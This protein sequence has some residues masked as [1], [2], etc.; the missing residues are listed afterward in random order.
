MT[1]RLAS[2]HVRVQA[3][4]V[5]VTV[6]TAAMCARDAVAQCQYDVSV[7]HG[8]WCGDIFQ[9][10]P[11]YVRGM[12]EAGDVVGYYKSCDLGPERA[13]V[14]TADAGL[15]T[16]N[17]PGASLSWAEDIAEQFIVGRFLD[18]N[19]EF[20]NMAFVSDGA[21]VTLIPPPP[22]NFLSA[23]FAVNESGQVVGTFASGV[24]FL[25]QD[26]AMTLFGPFP[27]GW[28]EARDVNNLGQVVGH[29]GDPSHLKA[30]A[31]A[32]IWENGDVTTLN[33]I[34]GGLTSVG[35][36][37]ND[38]G[39]VVGHGLIDAEELVTHP[40]I[41]SDGTMTDIGTL[42]GSSACFALD[43]NDRGTVVGYCAEFEGQF[44]VQ[45]AFIW[46]N[47]QM[48][49]LNDVISWEFGMAKAWA[50][51]NNG[52][53]TGDAV[54]GGGALLLTPVESPVGDINGDCQ[55]GIVDFLLLL[56]NWG[57]CPTQGA[58]VADVDGDGVVGITDF[59]LLLTNWG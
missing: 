1:V 19:T 11:T 44:N 51:N 35:L 30:T 34:P 8:P 21:S 49:D 42:P 53:I 41:W 10:P 12:N 56:S 20:S 25:W 28:S 59:L 15:V 18:P 39:Q 13:F 47:G 22:G 17:I 14:W 5:F 50:I 58:C 3:L 33:A 23:A 6:A 48:T 55:V 36:A 37:I 40:F 7:A 4:V 38:N 52:Q 46:Q 29:S 9:Y 57:L 24:S 26:G 2:N 45:R 16:L 27:L 54:G 43:I 31:R 32:Y